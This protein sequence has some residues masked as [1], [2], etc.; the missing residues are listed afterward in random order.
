M[1]HT[2]AAAKL[3]G[4]FVE[5]VLLAKLAILFHFDAVGRV[6]LVFVCPVVA[7]FTFGAGQCD[8]RPHGVT[9]CC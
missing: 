4:L 3:F 2:P 7:V 8:I 5:G 6:L 9:S 1:N